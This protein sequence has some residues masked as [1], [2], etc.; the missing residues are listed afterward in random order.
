MQAVFSYD[1]Y[2]KYL[3]EWCALRGR[4]GR[5]HLAQAVRCQTSYVTHVLGGAAHL[6]LEQADLFSNEAGFS[7][8][9]KR[10]FLTLVELGRAGTASL[11]TFLT[12][13]L[14][15]MQSRRNSLK[16]RVGIKNTLS[17]EEQATYYS[18]WHYAAVHVLTSIPGF[19]DVPAIA[20]E[21]GIGQARA[22][23]VLEFLMEAGL[24]EEDARGRL[25]MGVKQLHLERN[26]PLI[27][28]H[29]SNLRLLALDAMTEMNAAHL[30]YSS[31]FSLDESTVN[32]VK[33]ILAEAVQDAVEA[34]I[35]APE[36]QLWVMNVDWF[37]RG[38]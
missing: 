16:E 15:E 19:H 35:K 22:A 11:R 17:L 21:L 6:S 26:S 9:E 5:K 30:H 3:E 34:V 24:V 10:Y 13:Q 8:E 20:R 23:E 33:E 27:S 18:S 38:K 14:R 2:K 32:R 7:A 31:F 28:R 37:R 29:H 25:R 1:D 36:Q 12:E 4:G